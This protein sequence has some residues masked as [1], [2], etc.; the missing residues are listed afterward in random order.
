MA[1]VVKDTSGTYAKWPNEFIKVKNENGELVSRYYP[2]RGVFEDV[3]KG[4]LVGKTPMSGANLAK[5]NPAEQTRMA[6]ERKY[7]R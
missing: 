7:G 2:G 1:N 3:K 4:G 6:R 5:R